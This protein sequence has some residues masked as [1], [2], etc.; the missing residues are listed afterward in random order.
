MNIKLEPHKEY[1]QA[2]QKVR[3]S[4]RLVYNYWKLIEVTQDLYDLSREDAIEWTDFNILGLEP[5]GMDVSY[6]EPSGRWK[7]APTTPTGRAKRK[8]V[9]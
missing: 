8:K 5:M 7:P 9:K 3:P 6:A 1:S 4:G 2:I